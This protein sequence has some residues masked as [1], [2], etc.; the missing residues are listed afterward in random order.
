MAPFYFDTSGL[1]KR[2]I[3]ENGSTW[4]N[5]ICTPTSG[6]RVFIAEITALEIVSAITRRSRGGSLSAAVAAL[7]L[8]QFEADLQNEYFELELSSTVLTGALDF[9]RNYGLRSLD[10]IQLS[11][12]LNLNREQMAASLPTITLVSADSELLAAARGE[13]LLVEDP[14]NHP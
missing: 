8:A 2:Y 1:V 9:A 12:A 6:N 13:G 11:V 3:S 5:N 14:N 4:V 7:A 10:A